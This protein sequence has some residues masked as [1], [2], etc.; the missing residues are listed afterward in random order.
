MPHLE[1]ADGFRLYYE[2]HGPTPGSPGAGTP[3]LFA[4]GAGGNALSW[5]QQVPAFRDRYPVITFDHRAFGRS[6]DVPGGPGRAAFGA[7]VRALLQHLGVERVH[8]VAHSM[9]GRSGIGL[10][11]QEPARVASLTHSGT[12]AGCVDERYRVLRERLGAD[13]TLSGSLVARALGEGFRETEPDR[14]YLYA[15]VRSL[16]PGRARDFLAPTP[17]LL[18]ARGSTAQRLVESGLPILWI[19]GE[20]DR[21]VHPDLIRICHD[22]TP[23]SRFHLVRGAGHSAYFER[24]ADWNAAVRGFIDSVEDTLAAI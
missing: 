16:N 17:A 20:H 9:G 2:T 6:P 8:Y 14:A 12:N 13:G 11:V 23:G 4:H 10:L 22:L 24:S 18:R 19:V 1:L 21:V 5:W 3:V 7:D 15:R